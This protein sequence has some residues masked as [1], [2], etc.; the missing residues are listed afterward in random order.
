MAC[1]RCGKAHQRRRPCAGCTPPDG[2]CQPGAATLT[3]LYD[4]TRGC[5]GCKGSL[6]CVHAW[7]A[8]LWAA[9][10]G[11]RD[12]LTLDFC[13]PLPVLSGWLS[14][15]VGCTASVAR[16]CT[17][18]LFV[19]ALLQAGKGGKHSLQDLCSNSAH[20]S[21]CGDREVLVAPRGGRPNAFRKGARSSAAWGVQEA[22]VP[23][24]DAAG[25]CIKTR[26]CT[27]W[28]RSVPRQHSPA[29]AGQS[30]ATVSNFVRVS[31]ACQAVALVY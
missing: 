15:A 13:T 2:A 9:L 23:S 19:A 4:R 10:T 18:P 26:T 14:A 25:L 29:P 3:D 16:V 5:C 28:R 12:R 27:Q 11:A 21:A 1:T 30:L 22:G 20:D 8:A 17:R 6:H 7:C 24:A 31:G